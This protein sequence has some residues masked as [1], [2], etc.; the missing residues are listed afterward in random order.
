LADVKLRNV[1]K[2]FGK[3]IAVNKVTLDIGDGEFFAVLGPSGCGKTTLLRLIA[4]LEVPDEGDIIIGGRVVNNVHPRDRDV[5]MV[6]QNYALYPHMRVADNIA[7][8]LMVRRRELGLS[9]E[10]IRRRVVEIAKILG[11]EDLLD[12]YPRELSGGQQQRVALARALIRKPKVWLLDEP[13]SNLDAKLRVQMRAEIKA[14][15]RRFRVTTVYVTHDQGEAMSLADRI[16]V[17]NEGRIL[18][19]GTPDELYLKPVDTFVASFIGS[20]TMNLLPCEAQEDGGVV[21]LNCVGLKLRLDPGIGSLVL[22]KTR[23][24]LYL[25][26]RPEHVRIGEVEEWPRVRGKVTLV[27]PT[28]SHAII[29]LDLGGESF[30]VIAPRE[31]KASIGDE[32]VVSLDKDKILIYDMETGKLVV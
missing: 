18:Q 12:R 14:L 8:P 6:F 7:F 24:K 2:R 13:L 26:V 32:V 30:K 20:P 29:T 19:V 16:G 1:T 17:M 3:V 28:G 11:I 23:G 10:E 27:E 22:S 4:G 21:T 15:Q 25:G 5:A 31:F 9:S